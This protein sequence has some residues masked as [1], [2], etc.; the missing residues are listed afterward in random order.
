[1]C[2]QRR[3]SGGKLL[4]SHVQ[5]SSSRAA[6]A[7]RLA[8]RGLERSGSALGAFYRRLK[9]RLGMPKAITAAAHKLARLVYSLLKDGT[10]YV[11]QTLDEYERRYQE[12]AVRGLNRR[13]RELGY[14]LV[15]CGAPETESATTAKFAN[16][17]APQK[18]F[19]G[20]AVFE[21]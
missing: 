7:L 18:Y 16:G 6:Q 20:R 2:P 10:T 4:S 19:V 17:T 15:A 11:A 8:A 5:G 3:V 1:L 21:K 9:S 13:A 12:R 14:E